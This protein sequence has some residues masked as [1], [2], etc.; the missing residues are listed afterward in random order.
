MHPILVYEAKTGTPLGISNV[1]LLTRPLKAIRKK[2]KRYQT[3]DILIEAKE[4]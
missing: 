2:S 1:E 3:K 4:S